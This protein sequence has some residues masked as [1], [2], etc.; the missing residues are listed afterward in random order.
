MA[1]LITLAQAN[2]NEI[3]AYGA[4][5][6]VAFSAIRMAKLESNEY[7][8][9]T[10][11]LDYTGSLCGFEAQ[12]GQVITTVVDACKKHPRSDFLMLRIIAFSDGIG[13]VELAGFT[14][15]QQL[16]VSAL[17]TQIPKQCG[18]T[19]NLYDATYNAIA[20]TRVFAEK[21]SENEYGVNAVLAIATDGGDNA[22]TVTVHNVADELK[23][24]TTNEVC[25]ST[26]SILVGMNSKECGQELTAFQ[27]AVKFTQYEEQEVMDAHSFARLAQ[28]ISRSISAQSQALGTQQASAPLVL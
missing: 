3:E 20:A 14:P 21:L 10:L 8:L 16:D 24:L 28:F 27:N 2:N 4:N 25:E 22:S 1:K 7:T 13:I 17:A 5:K 19:T 18:G 9:A 6:A 15:V 11:A 26:L 23:K 12:L